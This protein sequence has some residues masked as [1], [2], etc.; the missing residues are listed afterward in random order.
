MLCDMNVFFDNDF[1]HISKEGQTEK[2]NV[3]EKSED[4][5]KR[6]CSIR[7]THAIIQFLFKNKTMFS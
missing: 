6:C 2:R 1:Q 5:M 7:F 4:V 3:N